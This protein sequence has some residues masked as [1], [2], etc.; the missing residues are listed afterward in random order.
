MKPL[1]ESVR[2]IKTLLDVLNGQRYTYISPVN[3]IKYSTSSDL[4]ML[5]SIKVGSKNIKDDILSAYFSK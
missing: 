3:D 2:K 1:S 5:D 4:G